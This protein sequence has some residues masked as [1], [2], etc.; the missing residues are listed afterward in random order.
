MVFHL[1]EDI[2]FCERAELLSGMLFNECLSDNEVFYVSGIHLASG[3]PVHSKLG[4]LRGSV[5]PSAPDSVAVYASSNDPAQVMLAGDFW[6][7]VSI[8]FE[9]GEGLVLVEFT[10]YDL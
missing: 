5:I 1:Q 2:W 9:V 10:L 7:N 4:S 6:R 3:P 8:A